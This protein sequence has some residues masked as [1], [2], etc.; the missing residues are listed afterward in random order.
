MFKQVIWVE[1]GVLLSSI[2]PRIASVAEN[3]GW[4]DTGA[5]EHR[6]KFC[7]YACI[8][9]N[10]FFSL[11]KTI[12]GRECSTDKRI[13]YARTVFHAISKFAKETKSSSTEGAQEDE[14]DAVSMTRIRMYQTLLED[15]TRFGVYK[16]T[17]YLDRI[18][19]RGRVIW[20][21]TIAKIAPYL[22]DGSNPPIYLQTISRLRQNELDNLISEIHSWA[23]A[24]ADRSI[25]WLYA[26][27]AR[28]I[29]FDE[30]A[31]A[32]DTI[33]AD[34]IYAISA[35]RRRLNRTFDYR[36]IWLLKMLI[37]IIEHENEW[38]GEGQVFGL[39]SFWRIWEHMCRVR[40]TT[41][42]AHSAL[43]KKMPRPVYHFTNSTK[44]EPFSRQIPDILVEE[45]TGV[46]W[47][48]DAKYYDITVTTP[49]WQDV[50]KQIFYA[51]TIRQASIAKSTISVFLFPEPNDQSKPHEIKVH[52]ALGV[53]LNG[54]ETIR[55]EYLDLIEVCQ[56][57]LNASA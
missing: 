47:I 48:R 8:D 40:Y 15:W 27:N 7:G 21:K 53:P 51:E 35:L 16:H 44:L 18:S 38:V 10:A 37:R 22:I 1:D 50:V 31:G 33:P 29:L 5:K 54:I 32:P 23:V 2:S 9:G 6:L 4:I 49:S 42:T 34:P 30:L 39:R 36:T 12:F 46:L 17:Q 14:A 11:P 24:R 26:S 56:R 52:D 45:S 43:I 25:G 19:S 41:L 20:P 3:R 55:C 13:A 28:T 57:Y